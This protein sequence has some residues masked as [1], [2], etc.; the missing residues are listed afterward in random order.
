MNKRYDIN[1]FVPTVTEQSITRELIKRVKQ[2]RKELSLTQKELSV[3][4]GV[5]YGSIR[6]FETQGEISLQAFMRISSVLKSLED[7][8]ELY[9]FPIIKDIRR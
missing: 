8:N 6:R 1:D 4:S 5:S 9:K 2:R 7:F 3:Q